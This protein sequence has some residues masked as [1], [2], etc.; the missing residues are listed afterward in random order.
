VSEPQAG[1]WCLVRERWPDTASRELTMRR[2]LTTPERAEYERCNPR[3]Q[4]TWLLGRIAAKDAARYRLWRLGAGPIF[5]AELRVGNDDQGRPW[6]C[7]PGVEPLAVSLAH[8]GGLGV[9]IVRPGASGGSGGVGIDIERVGAAGP[10]TESAA[11]T[12]EERDLLERLSGRGPAGSARGMWLTRFWTAKEAVGKAE[13][14]GLAGHPQQFVV[15]E[16]HVT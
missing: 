13:G 4:R 15:A 7:G 12:P 10:A 1:G 11:L 9:A 6:I 3:V 8:T 14:T 5:P 2:Y 16:A